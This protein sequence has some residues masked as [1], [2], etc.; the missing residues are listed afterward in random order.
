MDMLVDTVGDDVYCWSVELASFNP[1]SGL[2]KDIAELQKQYSYS[3]VQLHFLFK[4]GLHPFYPPRVEVLRPRFKTPISWAVA[5]HPMFHLS[6]WD[7]WIRQKEAILQI[8]TFLEK[9]ARVDLG[10]P[11]NSILDFPDAAYSDAERQ[12]AR[13]EALSELPPRCI[14]NPEYKKLYE[15]RDVVVDKDHLDA[16]QQPE[17]K[18]MRPKPQDREQ[19]WAAGTG[20]G[21]GKLES[22]TWDAK[23][24]DLAQKAHDAEVKRL[25]SDFDRS[26]AVELG[27][28]SVEED[29]SDAM[30]S[31]SSGPSEVEADMAPERLKALV[32]ALE[33]SCLLPFLLQE[34]GGASFT[35]MCGRAEYYL[36]I[37]KV[38]GAPV[39]AV[40]H[41]TLQL[42]YEPL[43]WL[44]LDNF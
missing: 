5:S 13:L 2:A 14:S 22:D 3:T 37:L 23:A 8:K 18:R 12:V 6:N 40:I 30:P 1:S 19:F 25:L 32:F 10:S 7:P 17:A 24:S 34:L 41:A 35:D 38:G 21:H 15:S 44:A 4:R 9:H 27:G 43:D 42:Q 31:T 28:P 26:L 36:S 16:L 11:M 33:G 20:Y 29:S 39:C